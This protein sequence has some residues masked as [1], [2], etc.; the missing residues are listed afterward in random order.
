[1]PLCLDEQHPFKGLLGAAGGKRSEYGDGD[2]LSLSI[3][4]SIHPYNSLSIYLST[5]L[6]IY[7]YKYLSIYLSIYLHGDP[8]SRPKPEKQAAAGGPGR[9]GHGAVTRDARIVDTTAAAA[10]V[11]TSATLAV[12]VNSYY[13]F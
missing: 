10:T 7:L 12:I 11:A 5:Y 8:L 13:T 4:L 9:E 6:S 3:Y 2:P 1:M